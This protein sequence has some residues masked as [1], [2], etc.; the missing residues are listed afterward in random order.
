MYQSDYGRARLAAA[1][2]EGSKVLFVRAV[3]NTAAKEMADGLRAAA[4]QDGE[5]F[6][7]AILDFTP[8][9]EK[10]RAA[11][12][13]AWIAFGSTRD[14]ADMVRTFRRLNYAPR[15]FFASGVAD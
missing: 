15:L 7:A 2:A 10:A 11:N 9:V 5:V 6:S 12:A 4:V 13:D 8:L 1:Q 14:A 3:D